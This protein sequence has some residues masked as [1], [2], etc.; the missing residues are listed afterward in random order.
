[1]AN[2][3]RQRQH[4][5]RRNPGVFANVIIAYRKSCHT[6]LIPSRPE[7]LLSLSLALV[8]YGARRPACRRQ[9]RRLF[10]F[11][12][13]PSSASCAEG[14]VLLHTMPLT[15]FPVSALPSRR[16]ASF[17]RTA[18]RPACRRQGPASIH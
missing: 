4:H 3:Q 9:A 18:V 17:W 5:N 14:G 15:L 2:P 10:A 7:S 1:R 11:T 6:V 16:A 8:L 13:A 12:G